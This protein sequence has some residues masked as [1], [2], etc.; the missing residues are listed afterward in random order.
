MATDTEAELDNKKRLADVTKK[1]IK[2][3]ADRAWNLS[4]EGKDANKRLKELQIRIKKENELLNK[5]AQTADNSLKI[6]KKRTDQAAELAT[7]EADITRARTSDAADDRKADRKF[8]KDKR[9]RQKKIRR[10]R[11]R[12]GC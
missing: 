3:E 7:L 10:C 2:L 4:K 6:E 8:L 12:L 9:K 11:K 1:L 5:E